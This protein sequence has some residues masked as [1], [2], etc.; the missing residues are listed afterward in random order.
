MFAGKEKT[1]KSSLL[2]PHDS[3]PVQDTGDIETTEFSFNTTLWD[4]GQEWAR[5]VYSYKRRRGSHEYVEREVYQST[6]LRLKSALEVG[7][8][9]RLEVG[10]GEIL[11]SAGDRGGFLA[12]MGCVGLKH[13][14]RVCLR[15]ILQ[16]MRPGGACWRELN[17]RRA[18][19]SLNCSHCPMRVCDPLVR[20]LED[21]PKRV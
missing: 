10:G 5:E 19:R 13:A 18:I 12:R 14:R 11:K 17:S 21:K 4:R 15:E 9:S 7:H 8:V 1:D 2:I 3:T 20:E 6:S 16:T